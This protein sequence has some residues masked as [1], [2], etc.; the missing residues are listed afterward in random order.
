MCPTCRCPLTIGDSFCFVKVK[1][2]MRIRNVMSQRYSLLSCRDVCGVVTL[3]YAEENLQPFQ[4]KMP[5][6]RKHTRTSAWPPYLSSFILFLQQYVCQY[7]HERD[8]SSM[9]ISHGHMCGCLTLCEDCLV[10]TVDL[11]RGLSTLQ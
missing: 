9:R 3:Q 4:H 10:H 6:T 1:P 5:L 11:S 2:W 8:Q 7:C